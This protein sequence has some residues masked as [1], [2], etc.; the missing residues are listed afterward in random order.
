MTLA[1]NADLKNVPFQ[2]RKSL[3]NTSN[4]D[5]DINTTITESDQEGKN[6]LELIKAMVLNILRWK[7][8]YERSTIG[9]FEWCWTVN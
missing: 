5:L 9:E 7:K 8:K 6:I 1:W 4:I 2:K 3:T